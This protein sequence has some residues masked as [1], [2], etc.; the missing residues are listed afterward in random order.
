MLLLIVDA[1]ILLLH[2]STIIEGNAYLQLG[3]KCKTRMLYISN[4]NIATHTK[5]ALPGFLSLTGCDSTSSF[6]GK[7]MAKAKKAMN[8]KQGHIEVRY[9]HLLWV[10]MFLDFTLF[11]DDCP[12][13]L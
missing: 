3:A 11:A 2:Y 4:R 9:C 5:N 8:S 12:L 6:Y 7:E 1:G 13:F 10:A